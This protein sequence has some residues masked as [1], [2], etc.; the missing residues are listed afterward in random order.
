MYKTHRRSLNKSASE[1]ALAFD[2]EEIREMVHKEVEAELHRREKLSR[3]LN[4]KEFKKFFRREFRNLLWIVF[5]C[6]Y[7]ILFNKGKDVKDVIRI[8][9][10]PLTKGNL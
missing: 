5:P 1:S 10:I 4:K 9:K 7:P 6:V 3:E 2:I 8:Y